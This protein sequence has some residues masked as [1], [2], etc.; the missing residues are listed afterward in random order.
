MRLLLCLFLILIPLSSASVEMTDPVEF[1]IGNGT[2]ITVLPQSFTE[3]NLYNLTNP[4]PATLELNIN[5]LITRFSPSVNATL[6]NISYSTNH[7]FLNANGNGYLTVKAKMPNTSDSYTLKIQSISD[8]TLTSDSEGWINFTKNVSGNK[9][10]EITHGAIPL[11]TPTPTTVVSTG[12]G[13]GSSS[14]GSGWTP[15]MNEPFLDVAINSVSELSELNYTVIIKNEGILPQEY[16]INMSITNYITGDI[17]DIWAFSKKITNGD[18]FKYDRLVT[19]PDSGTYIVTI[20]AKYSIFH[21][22]ATKTFTYDK[23]TNKFTS[24]ITKRTTELVD[25]NIIIVILL[26]LCLIFLIC[27]YFK[28]TKH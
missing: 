14:T 8:S 21:S 26:I 20:T 7:L 2:V 15:V 25:N 23:P 16:I 13:G 5:S 9:T 12:G 19:L 4:I 24:G 3:I 11:P 27:I 6:S 1:D 17:I 10:Y 18:T 22:V 28:K